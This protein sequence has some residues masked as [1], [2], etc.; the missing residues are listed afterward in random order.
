MRPLMSM[1]SR[2]YFGI[3]S[4]MRTAK[5]DVAEE[6]E[7]RRIMVATRFS[8]NE[9]EGRNMPPMSADFDGI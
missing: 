2:L 1:P 7:K 3:M 5:S 6:A 4:A 8:H 9:Q